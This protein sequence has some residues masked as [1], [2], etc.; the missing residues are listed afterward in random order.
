MLILHK[1]AAADPSLPK[2]IHGLRTTNLSFFEAVW[3]TAKTCT[4]LIALNKRFYWLPGRHPTLVN[5]QVAPPGPRDRTYSTVVD[6]VAQGGLEWVKVS[7][8]TEKRIIWDL[9]KA[10]WVAES[11]GEESEDSEGDDDLDPE[12]LLKQAESLVKAC[13]ATRVR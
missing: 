12:G 6:I 2:T 8:V 13:Q 4:D 1:L 5:G 3:S 7:S 9:A 10:G 11:S